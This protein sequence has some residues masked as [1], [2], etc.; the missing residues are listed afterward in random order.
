[1]TTTPPTPDPRQLLIGRLQELAD[2][3]QSEEEHGAAIALLILCGSLTNHTE[4]ML[5]KSLAQFAREELE[6]IPVPNIPVKPS[7]IN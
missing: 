1:M 6:R 4:E 2:Y 5:V 3:A 7:D